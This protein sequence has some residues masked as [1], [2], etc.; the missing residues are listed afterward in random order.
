MVYAS[1]GILEA[2]EIN[3]TM[4]KRLARVGA[5]SIAGTR[6]RFRELLFTTPGA[7]RWISGVIMYDETLRQAGSDGTPFPALLAERGMIT[8]IK[9]TAYLNAISQLADGPWELTFSYRRALQAAPLKAWS[10][11]ESNAEA[12]QAA[13]AHRA[14][15]NSEARLGRYSD[16]LEQPLAA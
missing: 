7:E 16:A 10:G 9:A 6:R 2:D 15:C 13:L 3:A 8:G 5:E 11:N 1:K 14:R 4:T 12:A